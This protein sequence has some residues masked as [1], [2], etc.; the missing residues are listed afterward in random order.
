MLPSN[1]KDFTGL[2][3]L[4]SK[5]MHHSSSTANMCVH[6]L[7]KYISYHIFRPPYVKF[8]ASISNVSVSYTYK[9][10]VVHKPWFDTMVAE[11]KALEDNHTWDIAPRSPGKNIFDY[12]WCFKVKIYICGCC[13]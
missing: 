7:N 10:A 6:H 1:Y 3:Y 13:A 11:I 2:P 9:Q 12:K 8:L 4:I 5:Q